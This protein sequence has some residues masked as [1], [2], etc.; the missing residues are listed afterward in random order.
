MGTIPTI[1]EAVRVS[2]VRLTGNETIEGVADKIAQRL[3][4]MGKEVK[5]DSK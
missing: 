4:E 3:R 2:G 5:R 1:D